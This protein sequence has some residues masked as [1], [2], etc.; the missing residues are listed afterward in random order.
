MY[1]P[2]NDYNN[3]DIEIFYE[4]LEKTMDTLFKKT[5]RPY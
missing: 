5:S 3:V 2:T 1:T 4:E